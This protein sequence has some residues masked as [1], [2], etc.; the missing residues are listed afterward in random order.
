MFLFF[1]IASQLGNYPAIP[2]KEWHFLKDCTGVSICEDLP[3]IIRESGQS[4]LISAVE[5]VSH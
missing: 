3:S 4:S 5:R 2:L 1:R